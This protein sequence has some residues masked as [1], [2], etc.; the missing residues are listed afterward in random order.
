M[1]SV[2]VTLLPGMK[3]LPCNSI[4]PP[5]TTLLLPLNEREG[6]KMASPIPMPLVTMTIMAIVVTINIESRR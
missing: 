4:V 1:S 6:W 3:F 2:R 5:E